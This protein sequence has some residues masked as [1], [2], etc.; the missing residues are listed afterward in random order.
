MLSPNKGILAIWDIIHAHEYLEVIKSHKCMVQVQCIPVTC[1]YTMYANNYI[2]I[3][4]K[5]GCD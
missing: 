4:V 1:S 5:E 2:I 3:A